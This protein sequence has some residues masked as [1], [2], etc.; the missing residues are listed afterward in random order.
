VA[1]QLITPFLWFDGQAEE[2]AAFYT[3]IFPNSSVVKVVRCGEGGPGP[4]GSALV[5]EFQLGGQKFVALNGG[6]HFKFTEAISFVVNCETQ[7]EVDT[8]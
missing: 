1:I 6:P 7:E 3:S 2:A 4:A 5:V 8:Y